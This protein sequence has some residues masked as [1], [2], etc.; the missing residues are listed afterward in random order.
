MNN[1]IYAVVLVLIAIYCFFTGNRI[2][3]MTFLVMADLCRI[4][5][6]IDN[7]KK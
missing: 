2:E 7:L 3:G 6:K 4:E 1:I 5:E